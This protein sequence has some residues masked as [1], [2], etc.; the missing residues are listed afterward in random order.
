MKKHGTPCN[1]CL[2]VCESEGGHGNREE[3]TCFEL[4]NRTCSGTNFQNKNFQNSYNFFIN[5][6][7]DTERLITL[8]KI[9][10]VP[11]SVFKL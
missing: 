6:S 4:Q 10:V 9:N 11:V 3:P 2:N 5:K 1:T 7:L 8:L